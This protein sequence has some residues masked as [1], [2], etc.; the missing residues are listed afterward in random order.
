MHQ[1]ILINCLVV[2]VVVFIHYEVLLRLAQLLGRLGPNLHRSRVVLAVLGALVAHALEVWVFAGGYYLMH[3]ADTFGHLTGNFTGSLMDC[4]YFSFTVFSTLGFGDIEPFGAIRYLAGIE[5]L[6]GLM[7][8]T[9]SASFLFIE[10]QR[11]WP[12]R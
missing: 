4:A 3:H 5:A 11:Y 12:N 8:I 10:M 2:V 6:T 1:V 7:L 9:W